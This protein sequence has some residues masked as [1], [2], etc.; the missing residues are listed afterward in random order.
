MRT[1]MRFLVMSRDR[2]FVEAFKKTM[3]E[4][5]EAEVFWVTTDEE[6]DRLG[7]AMSVYLLAGFGGFN[8]E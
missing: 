8:L 3:E 2:G 1:G 6:A 4:A 5:H 7:A